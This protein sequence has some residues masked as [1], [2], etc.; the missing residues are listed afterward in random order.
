MLISITSCNYNK[1][2]KSCIYNDSAII[3]STISDNRL[4]KL[5]TFKKTNPE[6]PNGISYEFSVKGDT[7]KKSYYT[8]GRLIGGLFEYYQNGRPKRYICFDSFN[9]DTMFHREYGLNNEITYEEGEMLYGKGYTSYDQSKLNT[10]G[11]VNIYSVLVSPPISSNTVKVYAI[12]DGF[13][14]DTLRPISTYFEAGQNKMI[15]VNKIL[16]KKHG[17][18]QL[19]TTTEVCDS[20]KKHVVRKSEIQHIER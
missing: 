17:R 2:S 4:I 8:D 3:C 5:Q 11:V 9:Q 15:L 14:K 6:I 18:Y 12:K 7:L 1:N 13:E 20:L 16:L 19:Y 10:E